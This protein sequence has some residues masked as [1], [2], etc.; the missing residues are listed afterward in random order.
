[1]LINPQ[2]ADPALRGPIEAA[3]RKGNSTLFVNGIDPGFSGDLLPL[4]G[5]AVSDLVTQVVVQEIF[6]YSTYDRTAFTAIAFGFGQK[7]DFTPPMATP[8]AVIHT[9][10]GML[11]MI[12]NAMGVQ[13]EEMRDRFERCFADHDF[14]CKMEAIP[15]GT[16]SGVRFA[17]KGWSM[18]SPSLSPNT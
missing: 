8:G 18:A 12:A 11:H 10:G 9:W 17:A 13:I 1:M 4:A 5:L 6:D 16:C 7:P 15:K 2:T 3:C 14:T